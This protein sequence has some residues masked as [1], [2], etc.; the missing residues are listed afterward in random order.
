MKRTADFLPALRFRW[1][2]PLYDPVLRM[3]IQEGTFKRRLVE[4]AKLGAG[5]C[6]LDLGCGTG[7]PIISTAS[8][9]GRSRRRDSS[10]S[11]RPAVSTPP[12]GRWRCCGR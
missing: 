9:R 8:C 1:L 6:V 2:T 4:Q 10:R 12:S 7:T 3:A 5:A 11:Q